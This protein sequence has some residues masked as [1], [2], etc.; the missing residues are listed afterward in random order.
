MALDGLHWGITNL[1][2]PYRTT[3]DFTFRTV[4]NAAPSVKG[5]GKWPIYF[6]VFAIIE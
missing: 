1:L 2:I 4:F 6:L 3:K 5:V